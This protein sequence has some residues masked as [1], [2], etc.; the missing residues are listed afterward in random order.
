MASFFQKRGA[1]L[2]LLS[3]LFLSVCPT[4]EA[5]EQTP[6]PRV[7]VAFVLDTTGSMSGLIEGAKRKIWSIANAIVDSNPG[8]AI[9]VGL[10]GYRDIG[11]IYVTRDYE[12][13]TDIQGIYGK[14]LTFEADGGGDTPE[15]VN[16]ALD[17][18]V[19]KLGWSNPATQ[20][21]KR[22][23]FL[24]GDAPP[25]MDYKQD[26][27]Y[28]E[29]IKEALQK[30]I[31]VN[32]VQAGDMS[33]TRRVWKEIAGLGKGDYLQIPQDG[34]HVVIIKTPYDIEIN[35]I[36]I[37]INRTVIPYGAMRDQEMTREKTEISSSP[38]VSMESKAEMSRY[39]SR[40]GGAKAA[41]T[42]SGDLVSDV[43]R[44]ATDIKAVP[45]EELPK[46]MRAMKPAERE[47]YVKERLVEREAL[48]AQLVEKVNQ[49][50]AYIQQEAAKGKSGKAADSFDASVL[51]T[52]DKQLK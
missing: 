20:E 15:S 33:E 3:A 50:D 51:R 18:A 22:I 4:V 46:E 34:G 32:A 37:R 27:K 16:E 35:T 48:T 21:A 31:I 28:P 7:E 29:I 25:H 41:I 5:E 52:L 43:D 10:V 23:L 6:Q 1:A 44:G 38:S 42:G 17:I 11:D 49:R 8:A 2:A 45:D 30:G 24:V 14:L 40:S 13:T 12:L 39:I 26:R 36:Q 9:Y 19:R 47:A